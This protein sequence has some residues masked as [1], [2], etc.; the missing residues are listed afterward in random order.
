[1]EHEVIGLALVRRRTSGSQI[2]LVRAAPNAPWVLPIA[3]AEESL[4]A[5][6]QAVHKELFPPSAILRLTD[7]TV[8]AE[9]VEGR[10]NFALASSDDDLH[11]YFESKRFYDARWAGY[12]EARY[13]LRGDLHEILHWTRRNLYTLPLPM[14]AA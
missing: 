7:S 3:C 14:T 9:I 12:S 6:L 10:A 13:I 11:P 2:L 1:M 4:E 5:L 8:K